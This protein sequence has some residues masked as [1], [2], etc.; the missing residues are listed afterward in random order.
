MKAAARIEGA[1]VVKSLRHPCDAK[2]ALQQS[3]TTQIGP[4]ALTD[5]NNVRGEKFNLEQLHALIPT[6]VHKQK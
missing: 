2:M 3:E 5:T 1:P 4:S 6:R